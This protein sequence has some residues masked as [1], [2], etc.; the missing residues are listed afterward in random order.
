MNKKIKII[1]LYQVVMHYRIPFYERLSSDNQIDF[2]LLYGK[3]KQ[4]SKLINSKFDS[5]KINAEQLNDLR[6]PLPFTPTLFTKL[7]KENPD[8]VF[9]EGS[10]SLIN[11]LIGFI[12]SKLFRKK[13]I[14]WSL[15]N[16]EGREYSG[17]RKII[18]KLE[19]YIEKKSDAIFTYSSVGKKYFVE[20]GSA[21][22][23]IFVSVNVLNAEEKLKEI[24]LLP[25]IE[26]PYSNYFNVAFIGTLTK[27]KNLHVLFE[28][29]EELNV[30]FNNKFKLH[31]IGDGAFKKNLSK[32]FEKDFVVDYGRINN[33]AGRI[34]KNC[35]VLVLP[36]LGGLAICEGM[37]SRLPIITGKA[38]GTEYDLVDN[39]NGFLAKEMS[40]EFLIEKILYLFENENEKKE[41][42][43]ISYHRITNELTFDKYYQGFKDLISYLKK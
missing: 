12:Y 39:H 10:S 16:L 7:I 6:I 8:V 31:I 21:P 36:G 15:G 11:G 41:M 28:A 9:S 3:G 14:W 1:C 25:K 35:D 29:V 2:K 37:V 42:G 27:D 40:K 43:E 18:N 33:G 34:L 5:Q 30:L 4:G 32:Y 13:F 26:F 19:N 22:Q 38:D 23:K 20:R 24:D 17:F